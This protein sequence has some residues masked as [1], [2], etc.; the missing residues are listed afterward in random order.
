MH[1]PSQPDQS[2]ALSA[3]IEG[4]RSDD[5]KPLFLSPG[6]RYLYYFMRC[7]MSERKANRFLNR[8][9]NR[10]LILEASSPLT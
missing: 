9:A 2:L 5:T 6:E 7:C 8:K 1:P 4:A 10:P 3:K